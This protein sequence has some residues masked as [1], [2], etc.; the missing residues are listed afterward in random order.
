MRDDS[1]FAYWQVLFVAILLNGLGFEAC[2]FY[3]LFDVCCLDTISLYGQY[4]VGRL[5]VDL[6]VVFAGSLIEAGCYSGYTAAAFDIRFE[7]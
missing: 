3:C 4:S 7:L 2:F 1:L 6:P 5:Q